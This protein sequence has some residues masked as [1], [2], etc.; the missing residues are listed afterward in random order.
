MSH[1]ALNRQRSAFKTKI[2][3]IGTFIKEFEPSDDS[4]K[5]TIQLSTKLTSV[6]DIFRRLNQIK[7]ESCALPDVNLKNALEVTLELE[8]FAEVMKVSLFVFLSKFEN[9]SETVCT[10]PKANIKIPD[11]PLPTFSGKFQEFQLLKSQFMNVI[12]NN[13]S[14]D[15]TQKLIL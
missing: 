13:S 5:D 14:L 7:C 4:K 2:N 1:A 3:K 8:N 15:E 10:V 11:L 12:G 9:E 6:N